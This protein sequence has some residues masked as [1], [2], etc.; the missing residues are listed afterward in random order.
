MTGYELAEVAG[1]DPR[2]FQSGRHKKA[3]YQKM[4]QRLL[5]EDHWQGELWDRR[6]DGKI[7][8]KWINITLIRHSDGR[9]Y[10]Y[11]AQF[12][13]ITEK[14]R[15]DELIMAQA[16]YDLLTNLPNRNLFKNRLEQEIKKSQR[17][18]LLL[19]LFFLDLDHFKDVNDTLGHDK[20]DELLKEV[21]LRILSCVRG[22]DTVARL[23]GDEFAV[24]LPDINKL[25]I[26]TIALH[27]IQELSKSFNLDQNQADCY[28]STSIGIVRFPEDG[29]DIES[30]MKHADQ[31]MYKAKLEG[32]GR[33]C[34]FT[35]SMQQEAN[36]KMALT[37]DLRQALVRNEL[38]VYYQPI[39]E[40][41]SGHIIKAEALLRWE[42][43]Q[44]GMINPDIFIAL[45][46][47]S[48]LI[49]EI[50]EWVFKQSIAFIDQWRKQF[51][52]IIQVSV[53][54][55][56]L[57]FKQINK[58]LWPERLTQLGLPGNSINVEITEGLLLKDAPI[59]KDRL[60]E[61]RNKGIEVSIDDFGT[62]FSSLSY[63]KEFD[64]DYIKIDRSFIS[65]LTHNETDRTL[66]EAIIAMAHKLDIR[67]IAEGVETKEQQE[68]LIH[69][70][71]DYVQGFL[72][73]PALP[74][75]EFSKLI[76]QQQS[77][78]PVGHKGISKNSSSQESV[79]LKR[80]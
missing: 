64:I 68:L 70:G 13:D 54:K 41:T 25:R 79:G 16:N 18:G 69:F 24:I 12:S 36:E 66:V 15:K 71:C 46:E 72:Y 48:G 75:E 58:L 77:Q 73:S 7:Q 62:G 1:K 61:F 33:F 49:L 44:R 20:G 55:S 57:Q 11:V 4:W 27:I 45:A 37:H 38:Q 28:I 51:G 31:A 29:T 17:S 53:N 40:I 65:N 8:A 14:K 6:K 22:T 23:G 74:A 21:A 76:I 9:I 78:A 59:V 32:R 30:L 56:P 39:L 50:G 10:C 19:S 67:I 2:I 3:F 5:E 47:E 26:E 60:L 52:Y 43:P 42:H 80:S 34:Y 63:L 35:R